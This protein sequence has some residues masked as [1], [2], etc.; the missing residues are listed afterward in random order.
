MGICCDQDDPTCRSMADSYDPTNPCA[1]DVNY[2][3]VTSY[4]TCPTVDRC[5]SG[6]TDLHLNYLKDKNKKQPA[7]VA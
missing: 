2:D 3:L 5:P 7:C 6:N 1:E 4:Y